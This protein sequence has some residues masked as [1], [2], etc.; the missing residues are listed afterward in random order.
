M[1]KFKKIMKIAQIPSK[2]NTS[3][4]SDDIGKISKNIRRRRSIFADQFIKKISLQN[5]LT[6]FSQM[7]PGH[8]II[9]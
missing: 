6:R 8:Q 7:Q 9:K 4:S 3:E 2:I 5:S 1:K